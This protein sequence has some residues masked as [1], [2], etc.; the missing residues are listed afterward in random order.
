MVDSLEERLFWNNDANFFDNCSKTFIFHAVENNI[1]SRKC[2][3]PI[4]QIRGLQ[5]N[6]KT[7]D[8]IYFF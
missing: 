8:L 7:Q 1:F 6:L 4:G 5:V 3:F 2:Q